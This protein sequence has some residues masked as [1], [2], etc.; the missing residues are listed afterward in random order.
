MKRVKQALAGVAIAVGVNAAVAGT[1][2]WTTPATDLSDSLQGASSAM[3]PFVVSGGML[4]A[5]FH[6]QHVIPPMIGMTG[7]LWV[8]ANSDQAQ[9]LLGGAGAGGGDITNTV[10][11]KTAQG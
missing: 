4:G 9:T 7:S 1:I 11:W 6:M 5:A 2:D 3:I 10:Y 8:A